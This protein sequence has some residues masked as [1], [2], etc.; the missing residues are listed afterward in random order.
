MAGEV[1]GPAWCTKGVAGRAGRPA[2]GVGCTRSWRVS[3]AL[4]RPGAPL[5]QPPTGPAS[6]SSLLPSPSA[7]GTESSG[8]SLRDE[9]PAAGPDAQLRERHVAGLA[10]AVP[11]GLGRVQP[12]VLGDPEPLLQKLAVPFQRL[13]SVVVQ[14]REPAQEQVQVSVAKAPPEEVPALLA[15]LLAQPV[16]VPQPPPVPGEALRLLP[17]VPVSLA[18]PVPQPVP[19]SGTVVLPK[20]LRGHAGATLLRLWSHGVPGGARESAGKIQVAVPVAEPHALPL[21]RER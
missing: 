17:E 12:A 9:L 20:G 10:P 7:L 19:L 4:S 2:C 5:P 15:V 6:G 18:R 16:A 3:F 13:Q 21:K 1:R 14:Q 8:R 11:G